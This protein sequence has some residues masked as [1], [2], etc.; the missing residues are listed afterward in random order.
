MENSTGEERLEFPVEQAID[1][2]QSDNK[3]DEMDLR[4]ERY[5]DGQGMNGREYES[6]ADIGRP[7]QIVIRGD[8][9]GQEKS[10]EN[11]LLAE[12]RDLAGRKQGFKEGNDR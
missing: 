1:K 5:G 7:P 3:N 9:F 10:S 6:L 8:R 12:F 11:E 4:A 2:G